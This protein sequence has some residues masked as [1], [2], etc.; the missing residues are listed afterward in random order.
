MTVRAALPVAP[1][2]AAVTVGVPGPAPVTRP[3]S[4]A[5]AWLACEVDQVIAGLATGWPDA[6]V[7]VAVK[8]IVSPTRTEALAG[9]TWTVIVGGGGATGPVGSSD[10][11][12][13]TAK[14]AAAKWPAAA[15]RRAIR[16]LASSRSR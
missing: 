16:I 2:L 12:Q 1:W 6:S 4:R 9:E 3:S 14:A 15:R 13:A 10:P 5:H 7:T 11:V 8:R